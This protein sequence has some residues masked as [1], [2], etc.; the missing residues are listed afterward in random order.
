MLTDAVKGGGQ[1]FADVIKIID[2]VNVQI[3]VPILQK[4]RKTQ[5]VTVYFLEQEVSH[6]AA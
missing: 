6:N 5:N 1:G 3:I 4:A 2:I